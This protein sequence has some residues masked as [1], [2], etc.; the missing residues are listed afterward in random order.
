MQVHVDLIDGCLVLQVNQILEKQAPERD[1][2]AQV[3]EW[4]SALKAPLYLF[5][6]FD[7]LKENDNELEKTDTVVW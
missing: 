2:G 4:V 3:G 5:P 1:G 6:G 7:P